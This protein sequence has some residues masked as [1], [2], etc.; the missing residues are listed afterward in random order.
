[1]PT[2]PVANSLVNKCSMLQGEVSILLAKLNQKN[3]EITALK[4]SLKVLGYGDSL[5]LVKT[6]K[7][8]N[9]TPL[10]PRGMLS[11]L[12]GEYIRIKVNKGSTFTSSDVVAYIKNIQGIKGVNTQLGTN[13]GNYLRKQENS[14]IIIELERS[15]D[16]GKAIIWKK[17]DTDSSVE[18]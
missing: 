13:V 10:L 8:R 12:S 7:K 1:M 17:L 18:N 5:H 16:T 15:N 9:K 2:S 3:T 11:R 14:G 4:L 6:C